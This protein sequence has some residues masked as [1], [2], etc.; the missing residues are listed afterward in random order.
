MKL[1]STVASA[2]QLHATLKVVSLLGI[3][4]VK[5]NQTSVGKRSLD[6]ADSYSHPYL[7][8]I[9]HADSSPNESS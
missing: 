6:S 4:V 5:L 7:L 2:V 3:V 8:P 1:I 9:H